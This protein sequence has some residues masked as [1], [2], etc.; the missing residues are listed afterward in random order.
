VGPQG[1]SGSDG[2]IKIY[3]CHCQESNPDRSARNL[4]TILT[5]L[6]GLSD[7]ES[8]FLKRS[9]YVG[10]RKQEKWESDRNVGL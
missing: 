1:R 8:K 2:K 10:R 9:Y 6:F 5:D 7:V 4:V 3:P